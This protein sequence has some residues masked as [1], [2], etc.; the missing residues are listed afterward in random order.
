MRFGF[1]LEFTGEDIHVSLQQMLSNCF[2]SPGDLYLDNRIN[3]LLL[4]LM[5]V[6][7]V[8]SI[9]WRLTS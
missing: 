4:P 6:D 3:D 7:Q 5:E 9:E 1:Q 2:Q 8:D